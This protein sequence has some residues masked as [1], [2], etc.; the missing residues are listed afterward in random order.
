MK[1]LPI[2]QTFNDKRF[3]LISLEVLNYPNCKISGQS[4]NILTKSPE[5]K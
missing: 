1:P 3:Y 4:P 2:S 5:N